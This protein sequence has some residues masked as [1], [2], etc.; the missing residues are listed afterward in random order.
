LA[1]VFFVGGVNNMYLASINPTHLMSE[2]VMHSGE[3]FSV[4]AERNAII[5]HLATHELDFDSLCRESR[6]SVHANSIRMSKEEWKDISKLLAEHPNGHPLRKSQRIS[7]SLNTD[8]EEI[9]GTAYLVFRIPIR[10][11]PPLYLQHPFDFHKKADELYCLLSDGDYV[12]RTH[13]N[14][15]TQDVHIEHGLLPGHFISVLGPK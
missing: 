6:V 5:S 10:E 7:A 8:Y 15:K 12:Y 14:L 11:Y 1:P 3:R 4:D 9:V 2:L 13:V